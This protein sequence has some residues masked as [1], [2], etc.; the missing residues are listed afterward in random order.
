MKKIILKRISEL[1][2]KQE[3]KTISDD[4]ILVLFRVRKMLNN[5]FKL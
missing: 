1:E 5:K 4:E 2:K 3:K